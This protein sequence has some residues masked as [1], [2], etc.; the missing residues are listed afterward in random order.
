M[1]IMLLRAYSNLDPS[2]MCARIF[3]LRNTHWVEGNRPIN[4]I[5][6]IGSTSFLSENPDHFLVF[7]SHSTFYSLVMSYGCALCCHSLI[8]VVA[9]D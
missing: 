7:G 6:V 4:F 5:I 3:L 1:C 8:K 9:A 2:P